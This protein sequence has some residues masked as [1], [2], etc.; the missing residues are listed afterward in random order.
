MAQKPETFKLYTLTNEGILL[1]KGWRFFP[2]DN[3]AFAQP[4][5]DDRNWQSIDPTQPIQ[6][7]PAIQKA[8]IGWLRLVLG[9]NE[10]FNQTVTLQVYQLVAS[11]IYLDG[12]LI[13]RFG[14]ISADPAQR[15]AYQPSGEPIA[16]PVSSKGGSVLA[17]RVAYCPLLS[18]NFPGPFSY[19]AFSAR[20]TTLPESVL[21]Y[22]DRIQSVCLNVIPSA[23]LLVLSLIHFAFFYYY[24]RQRANLYFALYTAL[25]ALGYLV[26]ALPFMLRWVFMQELFFIIGF[27]FSVIGFW[28]SVVAHYLLFS[29]RRSFFFYLI[30]G[31]GLLSLVMA[32][33]PDN[34]LKGL[35]GPFIWVLFSLELLRV[36]ILALR[37][38]K[39]GAAIIATGHALKVLLLVLF[40][41]VFR[42]PLPPWLD[43][44]FV[45]GL[46]FD[47][48]ALTVPLAMSLFLA[49]EFALDSKLLSLKLQEVEQLS[50]RTVAQEQE[51]QQ[52]LATQN[53]RLEGQVQQ[54]TVELQ[55]SL[56]HLRTTQQQLV[57]REKMASLGELTAGIA[58]EIQNPLNFVTNFSDVS[59]ELLHELNEEVRAGHTS[60]VMAISDDLAQNL[61][62]IAHHGERASAIVTSMLEHSR[63]ST[64]E[65]RPTNLNALLGEYLTLAYQGVRAKDKQF[66]C[67]LITD[68]DPTVGD[69]NVVPQDIGRVVLNLLNNGFYAI[70]EQQKLATPDYRPTV[71]LSTQRVPGQPGGEN[72]LGTINLCIRDN[73]TG[74]PDSVKARIFQPFFTTKPPGQGTGLGL[75]LSYDIIT[76]GHN[77]QLLVQTEA[78]QYTEFIIR[79]PLTP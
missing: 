9:P 4:A 21:F 54:R 19:S 44:T 67:H 36:T 78:G 1:D 50:A 65:R 30:T 70:R 13:Q 71:W 74:I 22:R 56:D 6:E 17:V 55:Q 29:F 38:R 77:G 31:C 16:F 28:Y 11:E 26:G 25:F 66:N 49:R 73:G 2:G 42:L 34:P 10:R 33:M 45:G 48:S 62:K 3:P 47:L 7:L 39:R 41:N 72:P 18:P 76:Q 12:R 68:F 64:G 37:K 51:K 63:N 15:R 24:R 27:G 52:L 57:Q 69:V 20:I 43:A 58:H 14:V 32:H 8:G 61:Q 59:I 5:F 79:L 60:D 46:F 23:L 35:G 53:E 40:I 75:S